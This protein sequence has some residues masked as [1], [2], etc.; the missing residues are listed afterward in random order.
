MKDSKSDFF[1]VITKHFSNKNLLALMH[2]ILIIK[3][4]L[5][6]KP[7]AIKRRYKYRLLLIYLEC[8]FFC[9]EINDKTDC[10]IISL[11]QFYKRI[12]IYSV[13]P[14]CIASVWSQWM[15]V[16]TNNDFLSFNYITEEN[17]N[18]LMLVDIIG[19]TRVIYLCLLKKRW[20]SFLNTQND[21]TLVQL[22]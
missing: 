20:I 22:A 7:M 14:Q 3:W 19:L 1:L 6:Q 15:S 4:V 21:S 5:S 10:D 17:Q 13:L 11:N 18:E 8:V 9:S 12:H 16:Q 2:K